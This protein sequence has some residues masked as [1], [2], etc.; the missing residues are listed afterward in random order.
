MKNDSFMKVESIAECSPWSRQ[1]LHCLS[2][3][4][5]IWELSFKILEHL[6]YSD[7]EIKSTFLW[8]FPGINQ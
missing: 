3:L 2:R 6:P 8:Q 5:L 7:T 4:F 1:I